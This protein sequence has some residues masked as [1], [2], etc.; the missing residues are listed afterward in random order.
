MKKYG[1]SV[2]IGTKLPLAVLRVNSATLNANYR[3]MGTDNPKG[4]MLSAYLPTNKIYTE[5]IVRI[6]KGRYS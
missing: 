4:L 1:C 2:I 3:H 5:V 6:G